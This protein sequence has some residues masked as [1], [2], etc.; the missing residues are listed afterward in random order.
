MTVNKA[1]NPSVDILEEVIVDI[2]VNNDDSEEINW[3]YKIEELSERI[4]QPVNLN[5]AT[6][7]Q[8]EQLPFLSDIQIENLLAYVYIHGQMQTIYELQLV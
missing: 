8:L 3:D 4:Q 6:K 2:S 5:T 1:Q 7:E